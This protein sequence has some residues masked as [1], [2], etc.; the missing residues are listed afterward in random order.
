MILRNVRLIRQARATIFSFIGSCLSPSLAPQRLLLINSCPPG[1]KAHAMN[2]ELLIRVADWM[3][4][5]VLWLMAG[6][7]VLAV[8][9]LGQYLGLVIAMALV[10]E[11]AILARRVL[12]V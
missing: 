6:L 12:Q 7:G 10:L 1:S 2:I 3:M 8:T 4:T 5:A 11:G 9:A